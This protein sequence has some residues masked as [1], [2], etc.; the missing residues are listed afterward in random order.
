MT[1]VAYSDQPLFASETALRSLGRYALSEVLGAAASGT[2]YGAYDPEA[3]RDVAINLMLLL[4]SR[5]AQSRAQLIEEARAWQRFAHPNVAR[6][7]DVG[8]FVD[9]RDPSGRRAGV[10][11]VRETLSGIDLQRWLDT[12]PANADAA[13][14]DRILDIFCSA[15]KG[16][17]AAHANGLVHRDF[18]PATVIVGYDGQAHL[19]DFA[20]PD[21]VP[22]AP[23]EFD[24]MPRF[25]APEL[26]TGAVADALADQYSFCASLWDALQRPTGFRVSRRLRDVITRGMAER[27]EDR[28][29]SMVE[30]LRALDRSRSGLLRVIASAFRS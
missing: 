29:P 3:D 14:S 30:L 11:V 17:A 21:A 12:L 15:G 19:V 18:R 2:V 28:W 16:L 25:P 27:P 10:Y 26:R 8:T 9:P 20:S 22:M 24:E 5:G 23:S 7:L 6:I 13:T 1:T 4:R